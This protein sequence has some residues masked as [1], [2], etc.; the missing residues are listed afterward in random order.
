[1]KHRVV[2]I[3]LVAVMLLSFPGIAAA[4]NLPVPVFGQLP[5]N[6][7]CWATAAS[8]V[9]AY[10]KPDNIDRKV[11]IAKMIH[12]AVNYNKGGTNANM[13]DAVW[14]YLRWPGSI[15]NNMLSYTAVQYQTNNGGPIIARMSKN[16][17]ATLHALTIRGYNTTGSKVFYNDPW[18]G[19]FYDKYTHTDLVLGRINDPWDWGIWN[20]GIFWR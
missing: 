5:L 14:T 19:K 18:N 4:A 20:A 12:G 8:M 11:D 16:S 10:G 1:M 6:N 3:V 15:Q 9:I 2:A 7:L 13:R 17:G